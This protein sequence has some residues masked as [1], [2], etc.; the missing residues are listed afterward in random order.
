MNLYFILFSLAITVFGQKNDNFQN[1]DFK[2]MSIFGLKD[3]KERSPFGF[4]EKISFTNNNNNNNMIMNPEQRESL[5]EFLKDLNITKIEEFLYI[6]LDV[7]L[8]KGEIK[9]QIDEWVSRQEDSVKKQFSL[10]KA[11]EELRKNEFERFHQSISSK[12][13]PDAKDVDNQIMQLIEN[14]NITRLD[15]TLKIKQIVKNAP[16]SAIR[17]LAALY[18]FVRS[19]AY[20]CMR[21]KQPLK[22]NIFLTNVDQTKS[23]FG[24]KFKKLN[25]KEDGP[26]MEYS[27]KEGE[28]RSP[29]PLPEINT[30]EDDKKMLPLMEKENNF[31]T[32]KKMNDDGDSIIEKDDK[33][34]GPRNGPE[35]SDEDSDEPENNDL[36]PPFDK[37]KNKM[38]LGSRRGMEP[39]FDRKPFGPGGSNNFHGSNN[40]SGQNRFSEGGMKNNNFN[41]MPNRQMSMERNNREMSEYNN[42]SN[43]RMSYPSNDSFKQDNLKTSTSGNMFN[44]NESKMHDQ[45]PLIRENRQE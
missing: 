33:I 10:F 41:E 31:D 36:R 21:R 9:E 35:D 27:D 15:E 38:T 7:K 37:R 29:T 23:P 12:F 26:K 42:N 20:R 2:S 28:M 16:C 14:E 4:N 5:P 8:T 6:A 13:F 24:M 1:V 34:E 39:D 32:P 40:F 30:I 17:Q 44:H 22:M 19:E 11:K 45:L 43:N 3:L 25:N 18:P